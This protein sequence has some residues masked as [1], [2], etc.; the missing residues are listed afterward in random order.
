MLLLR[1]L[2]AALLVEQAIMVS[3]W[4]IK[5]LV[6]AGA[7]L[8]L[9]GFLTPVVAVLTGLVSLAVVFSNLDH[10]ELV[11]L[12]GV[13]ALLGPGAFSIDARLFG[14]REVLIPR[15]TSELPAAPDRSRH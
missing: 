10:L 2:V 3:G 11:V 14:R 13:I 7:T 1:A 12:T 8:L 6:L 15:R 4:S 5:A 9:L